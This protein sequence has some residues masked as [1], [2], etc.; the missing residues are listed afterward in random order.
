MAGLSLRTKGRDNHAADGN[1]FV[2]SGDTCRLYVFL[3]RKGELGFAPEM[4]NDILHR[5][6][7]GSMVVVI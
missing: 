5:L 1:C 6:F 3:D 4:F 7:L 2:F